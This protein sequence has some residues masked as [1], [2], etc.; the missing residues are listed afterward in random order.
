MPPW[1]MEQ[2][3]S[4]FPRPVQRWPAG[5]SLEYTQSKAHCPDSTAQ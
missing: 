3:G 5:Q 2:P 1:V 4:H